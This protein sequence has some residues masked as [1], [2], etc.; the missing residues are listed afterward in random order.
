M[1]L[2]LLVFLFLGLFIDDQLFFLIFR[3]INR[4]SE[5][6]RKLGI[7]SA[8]FFIDVFYI[9]PNALFPLRPLTSILSRKHEFEADSYAAENAEASQ[10]ISAL[11][12]LYKENSAPVITNKWFS[13]F[14][15]SHPNALARINALE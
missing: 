4:N 8:S 3:N 13:L 14:Y 7:L 11:I 2:C 5:R 6:H 9:M 12:K 1:H 15:D 10:L